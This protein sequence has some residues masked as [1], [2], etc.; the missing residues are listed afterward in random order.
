MAGSRRVR[1][2]LCATLLVCIGAASAVAGTL[3]KEAC[4]DAH[5]RGQDARDAGK[6][7]FARRL[8]LSCARTACPR[9]V[10][11]DCARLADELEALQPTVSFVAREA[12]GTD[13]A[14]ASVYVD[15]MLV[16][17]RLDG[18]P[19]DVDPGHHEIRFS[20]GGRDEL[21]TVVIGTGEKARTIVGRF[22]PS[23]DTTTEVQ[24]PASVV[25]SARR[26]TPPVAR[27]AGAI[28]LVVGGGLATAGGAAVAWYGLTRLPASCSYFARECTGPPGD[29]VFAEAEHASRILNAGVIAGGLGLVALTGGLIW[30]VA[31]GRPASDAAV[32]TAWVGRHGGGLALSGSF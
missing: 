7:A 1:A 13:L 22:P 16:A 32:P 20:H 5:S 18:R 8:F 3:S 31:G 24:E 9:I 23:A 25:R 30:Y 10:Q 14:D 15:G 2:V 4:V 28:A 6:L 17:T 19:F 26:P 12:D 21:V 11:A 27:P 29:P